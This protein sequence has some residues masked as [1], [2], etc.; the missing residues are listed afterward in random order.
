MAWVAGVHGCSDG[1]AVALRPSDGSHVG[2]RIVASAS[3]LLRLPER[4]TLIA[5]DIPIG[6]LDQATPRGRECD[7]MARQLLKAR[8]CCVFTPPVRDALA[9][10]NYEDANR[11]NAASSP[12]GIGISRQRFG[13]FK[14]I[15]EVDALMTPEL[16]KRIREINPELC[17]MA[18]NLGCPL[19]QSKHDDG[20]RNRRRDLLSS[21]GYGQLVDA[22]R[23]DASRPVE[24]DVLDACV[25]CW[26]AERI[27]RGV[28]TR[29]PEQPVYDSRGLSMEMWWCNEPVAHGDS[30]E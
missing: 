12:S 5:I 6:L 16:Q 29:I 9:K 23:S 13:L 27:L 2:F 28:A 21:N 15:R 30:G 24:E 20:G 25:A 11:A 19:P 4:P 22:A 18:M 7:R 17:F 8:A 3:E 26:T 10:T 14:K 1:W